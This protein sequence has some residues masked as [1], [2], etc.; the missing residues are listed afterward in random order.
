M[1]L[2]CAPSRMYS[3][4][5]LISLN[6][7]NFMEGCIQGLLQQ[8]FRSTLLWIRDMNPVMIGEP[9]TLGLGC[10]S[11]TYRAHPRPHDDA[12]LC[13]RAVDRRG[14][15]GWAVR[16]QRSYTPQSNDRG[17]SPSQYLHCPGGMAEHSPLPTLVSHAEKPGQTLKLPLPIVCVSFYASPLGTAGFNPYS[18]IRAPQEWAGRHQSGWPG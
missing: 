12:Q 3:S 2:I 10:C 5:L 4:A 7:E 6:D 8:V 11:Q 14:A 1:D 16:D 18:P 9:R 13:L 17:D 15:A